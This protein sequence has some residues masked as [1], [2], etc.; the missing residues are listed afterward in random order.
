MANQTF[1]GLHYASINRSVD[2]R[3]ILQSV[4]VVPMVFG[5]FP[6]IL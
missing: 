2:K 3:A 5:V 4:E 1:V 6:D